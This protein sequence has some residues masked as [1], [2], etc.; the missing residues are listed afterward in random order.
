LA[1]AIRP[2]FSFQARLRRVS[3]KKCSNDMSSWAAKYLRQ[4]AQSN[5]SPRLLSIAIGFNYA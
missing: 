5:L 3:R 4:Q 1:Y 2:F